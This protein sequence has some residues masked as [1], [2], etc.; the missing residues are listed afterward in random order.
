MTKETISR[1][2]RILLEGGVAWRHVRRYTRELEHHFDDLC[3]Q[4][5]ADG[6]DD[7]A[8]TTRAEQA[9]GDPGLLASEMLGRPELQSFGSRY[10]R[11][12]FLALPVITYCLAIL[13]IVL[14]FIATM[15]TWFAAGENYVVP[16]ILV[17]TTIEGLRLFIMHAMA[18]L[19]SAVYL[20]W[21]L[22]QEIARRWLYSG[23][24]LVNLLGCAVLVNIQFPDPAAGITEGF[25]GGTLGYGFYGIRDVMDT[26]VR[27]LITL[28]L[29]SAFGWW[30]RRRLAR[31]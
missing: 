19:V 17:K 20:V 15:E 31:E 21:G 6:L 14:L 2:R 27:L 5:K 24:F 1:L 26:K 4:G 3:L 22:R 18:P 29:L 16:G 25:I 9:L 23:V 11:L 13:V 8:A 12:V 30:Y 10:P 7:A 28:L